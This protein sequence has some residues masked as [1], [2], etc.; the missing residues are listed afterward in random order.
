MHGTI[1]LLAV[2]AEQC[3]MHC[4]PRSRVTLRILLDHLRGTEHR[5]HQEVHALDA[6]IDKVQQVLTRRIDHLESNLTRQIDAIDGR[7]DAVEIE[8]LPK[9]LK[10]I[11]LHLGL[12]A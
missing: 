6:K 2:L 9:R 10:K 8:H 1:V 7:L 4:M 5:L 11:E 3:S 12:A